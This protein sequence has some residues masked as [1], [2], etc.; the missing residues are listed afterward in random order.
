MSKPDLI[1]VS[2]IGNGHFSN[3]G[4]LF[5]RIWPRGY[6]TVFMLNS[7]EYEFILLINVKMPT[8]LLAFLHLPAG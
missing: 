6:K 1:P 2:N 4:V 8:K 7:A 3:I 5:F